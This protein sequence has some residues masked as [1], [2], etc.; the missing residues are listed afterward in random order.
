MSV[1][2]LAH[3]TVRIYLRGWLGSVFSPPSRASSLIGGNL[4]AARVF[5]PPCI[6]P[7]GPQGIN[8]TRVLIDLIDI[9]LYLLYIFI[10]Y[11]H[12]HFLI[13]F[14][15]ALGLV[16]GS[17]PGV[18]VVPCRL[19]PSLLNAGRNLAQGIYS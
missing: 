1:G 6:P 7:G 5:L 11:L 15:L 14:A 2:C 4:T 17:V 12:G 18:W 3:P 19:K 8:W 16:S 9:D 13:S 10:Q